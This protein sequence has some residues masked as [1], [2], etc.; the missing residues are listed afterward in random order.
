[1]VRYALIRTRPVAESPGLDRCV[2]GLAE[3]EKATGGGSG[4][5]HVVSLDR[6]AP[7][8]LSDR[9]GM[10][11][12]RAVRRKLSHP[13]VWV[14]GRRDEPARDD[15]PFKAEKVVFMGKL[16]ASAVHKVEGSFYVLDKGVVDGGHPDGPVPWGHEVS[17]PGQDWLDVGSNSVR[18]RGRRWKTGYVRLE[19]W[20]AAP[21]V[22]AS[23]HRSWEGE[24]SSP[25]GIIYPLEDETGGILDDRLFFDLGRRET[26]WR[27]RVQAKFLKN[28]REPDFPA[29]AYEVDFFKIQFWR[30]PEE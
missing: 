9:E 18:F 8:A 1:M 15:A 22:D 30:H 3:Q 10:S 7:Y 19:L 2:A 20:S 4:V 14:I 13:S 5:A 16:L 25:S 6:N 29:D 23:W 12:A 26:T 17:P 11:A 24:L 28:D 21:S 27:I